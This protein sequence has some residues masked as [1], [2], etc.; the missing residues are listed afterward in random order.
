MSSNAPSASST[1]TPTRAE[2]KACHAKRDAYF[3]CLDSNNIVSLEQRGTLCED[4][5]QVMFK[6]CPEVWA[7]Y[8]EQLR[9]MQ[10]KKEFAY[11]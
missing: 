2:R 6:G 10:K 4:L 7:N 8:F 11:S 9:E 5:R 1:A 3:S